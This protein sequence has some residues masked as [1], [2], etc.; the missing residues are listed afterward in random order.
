MGN[1]GD[2]NQDRPKLR[3][4]VWARTEVPDR[5]GAG[6]LIDALCALVRSGYQDTR[7]CNCATAI[8]ARTRIR[9]RPD[10]DD[11]DH[12]DFAIPSISHTRRMIITEDLIT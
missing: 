11:Y 5:H 4:L 6:E 12:N 8:G 10:R 3:D 2:E 1:E 7:A 9:S